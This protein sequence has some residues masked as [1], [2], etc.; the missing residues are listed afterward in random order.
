M[1][2]TGN[3]SNGINWDNGIPNINVNASVPSFS[4]ATI[5]INAQCNNLSMFLSSLTINAGVTLTVNGILTLASFGTT[6]NNGTL[7]MR[8][9]VTSN[10]G[11]SQLTIGGGVT[12]VSGLEFSTFTIN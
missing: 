8:Q 1:L 2:G 9:G 4:T 6:T 7:I 11:G 10:L 3:W 5:D 12:T